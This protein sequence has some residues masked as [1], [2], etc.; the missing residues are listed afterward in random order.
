LV[1]RTEGV[2]RPA[3]ELRKRWLEAFPASRFW[4]G[5]R[6]RFMPAVD[7]TTLPLSLVERFEHRNA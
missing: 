5:L 2:R 4:Q 7:E 6:G 1:P 3:G